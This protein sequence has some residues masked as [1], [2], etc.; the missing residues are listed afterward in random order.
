MS[1]NNLHPYMMLARKESLKSNF[2]H[3][4]GAILVKGGTVISKGYNQIRF[5]KDIKEFA[6][7]DNSLH[8]ERECLRKVDK[9]KVRGGV[10]Y[11]YREH[12]NGETA[13]ALPCEYCFEMLKS[14]GVKK[15][16]FS[17]KDYPFYGEIKL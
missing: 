7:W 10:I 16:V 4:I 5:S 9:D 17:Q 15:I 14:Y 6:K 13:L 8:A 3:K 1:N 11:I 12:K 2:K